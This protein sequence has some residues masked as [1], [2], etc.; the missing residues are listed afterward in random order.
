MI[1]TIATGE[2]PPGEYCPL[3][4]TVCAKIDC[5]RCRV[6]SSLVDSAVWVCVGCYDKYMYDMYSIL[7]FHS[8][9][10][11]HICGFASV[12]LLLTELK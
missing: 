11:C 7:P 6:L 1:N 10:K 9:G 8:T 4:K 3:I 5:E 12:A 2:K